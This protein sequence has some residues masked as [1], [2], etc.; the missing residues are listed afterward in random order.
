MRIVLD[1]N[2]LIDGFQDDYSAEAKL[3]EAVRSGELTAVA[4]EKMLKEYRLILGRLIEDAEYRGKIKDFFSMLDEAEPEFVDA[5]IDD[6]EDMKFLEAAVGGEAELLVTSDRHLLDVGEADGVRIVTPEEA[7]NRHEE[8]SDG[9]REWQGLI[10][11]WG[12]EAHDSSEE[13][14]E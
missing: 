3:V 5:V 12:I 11:G 2:V 14:G 7:M 10:S 4:S 1:T 6:E 8:E 13:K 9:A